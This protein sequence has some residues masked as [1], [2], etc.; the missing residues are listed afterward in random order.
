MHGAFSKKK[1]PSARRSRVQQEEAAFSK[2]K[3]RSARRSR[4]HMK[5]PE[6]RS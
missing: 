5:N 4:P 3:P 6:S 1:P 2:K